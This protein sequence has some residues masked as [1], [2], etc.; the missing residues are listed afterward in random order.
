MTALLKGNTKT[1]NVQLSDGQIIEFMPEMVHSDLLALTSNQEIINRTERLILVQ[2][3]SY[4]IIKLHE[5]QMIIYKTLD[6]LRYH[7]IASKYYNA[8]LS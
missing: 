3:S 8:E 5:L 2:L 7:K 4:T 1:L 6:K